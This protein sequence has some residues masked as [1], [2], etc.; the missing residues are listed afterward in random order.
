MR[1]APCTR[2]ACWRCTPSVWTIVSWRFGTA[3]PGNDAPTSILRDSIPSTAMSVPA[4]WSLTPRFRDQSR[5]V[6]RRLIFC[7]ERIRTSTYGAPGILRRRAGSS[8]HARETRSALAPLRLRERR[9]LP[10]DR[11]TILAM[12]GPAPIHTVD[13][14]ILRD[15]SLIEGRLRHLRIAG[16]ENALVSADRSAAGRPHV[17]AL[18]LQGI[19]DQ[20]KQIVLERQHVRPLVVRKARR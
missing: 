7:A 15:G 6:R 12:I 18:C 13:G 5:G 10:A 19:A 1:F 20:R 4:R 14:K 8:M 3:W 11:L 17:V 2:K 16:E 9:D